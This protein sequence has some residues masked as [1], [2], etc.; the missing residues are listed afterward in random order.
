MGPMN[1]SDCW[2]LFAM[3]MSSLRVELPPHS[4][5]TLEIQM[6][7]LPSDILKIYSKAACQTGR[8]CTR[9]SGLL[10]LMPPESLVHEELFEPVSLYIHFN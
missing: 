10:E 6:T 7:D 5:H 9:K 3:T 1:S 2:Y 4:D 8:A